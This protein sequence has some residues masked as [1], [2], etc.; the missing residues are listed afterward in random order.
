[1]VTIVEM[2][3]S[4]ISTIPL[5]K[6]YDNRAKYSL[7]LKHINGILMIFYAWVIIFSF[8]SWVVK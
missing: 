4:I 7:S 2:L 3:E 8:Y 1:M 6:F 5:S